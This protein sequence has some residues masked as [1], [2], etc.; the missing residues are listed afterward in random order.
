MECMDE[1][2]M[3]RVAFSIF[4]RKKNTHNMNITTHTL[5]YVITAINCSFSLA[6]AIKVKNNNIVST[7]DNCVVVMIFNQRSFMMFDVLI[8]KTSSD[9]GLY[10]L[11]KLANL[12][13][14]VF[15][16]LQKTL[17]MFQCR[18]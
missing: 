7:R 4:R 16:S 9:S 17:V 8:P 5:L 6:Y 18:K 3:Y 2:K 11:M 14:K 12:I 10:Y 1:I 15:S 13:W